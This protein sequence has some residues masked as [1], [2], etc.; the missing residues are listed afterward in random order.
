[1]EQEQS[2]S[3]AGR[4]GH[5]GSS[6]RKRRGERSAGCLNHPPLSP[7]QS[8]ATT[9]TNAYNSRMV[10]GGVILHH[11][12]PFFSG[13]SGHRR[14]E[15]TGNAENRRSGLTCGFLRSPIRG[16]HMTPLGVVSG[17]PLND[18]SGHPV[19][20]NP[21]TAAIAVKKHDVPVRHVSLRTR[22]TCRTGTSCVLKG[23]RTIV[24]SG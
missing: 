4:C 11:R 7:D 17:C 23:L 9:A 13:S 14:P 16:G 8:A 12:S 3:G 10:I 15:W 2:W 6:G 18:F 19:C 5:V 22:E 20:I 24:L 1:M 21:F